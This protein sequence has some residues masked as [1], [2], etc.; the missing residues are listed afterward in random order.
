M[1]ISKITGGGANFPRPVKPQE[2]HAIQRGPEKMPHVVG[3]TGT[4][5]AQVVSAYLAQAIAK[6]SGI[7]QKID[8]LA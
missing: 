8:L 6:Q 2:V 4:P 3:Q 1:S 5:G 7:G